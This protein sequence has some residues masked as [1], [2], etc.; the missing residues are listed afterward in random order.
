MLCIVWL[1]H[2][3]TDKKLK[4]KNENFNTDKRSS[5]DSIMQSDP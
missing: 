1:D 3:D 5:H 4:G 2:Y